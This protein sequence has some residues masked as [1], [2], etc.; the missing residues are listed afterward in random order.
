MPSTLSDSP[1]VR[2]NYNEAGIASSWLDSTNASQ[3]TKRPL[4]G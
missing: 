2:H 3:R 4:P 1:I